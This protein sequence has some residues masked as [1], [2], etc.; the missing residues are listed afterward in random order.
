MNRSSAIKSLAFAVP[1]GLIREAER[2]TQSRQTALDALVKI[3]A[4]GLLL[5]EAD[6]Q[7]GTAN[8]VFT[9]RRYFHKVRAC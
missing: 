1:S 8:T 4:K 2:Q 5:A 6:H 3:A 7:E 9:V